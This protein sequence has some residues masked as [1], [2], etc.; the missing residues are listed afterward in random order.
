MVFI[1]EVIVS[2]ISAVVEL[3]FHLLQAVVYGIV[4]V[5][6][7]PPA[8]ES[9]FGLKNLAAAAAPLLVLVLLVL[10]GAGAMVLPDWWERRITK[11]C[12]QTQAAVDALAGDLAAA[13]DQDHVAGVPKVGPANVKDAWGNPLDVSFQRGAVSATITVKSAGKDEKLGTLD[14][15]RADHVRML[16]KGEIAGNAVR[17]LIE[18][19]KERDAEQD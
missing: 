19:V 3:V 5:A 1:V 8:G 6:R 15:I 9:R 16:N 10:A 7:K 4:R 2:G 13:F 18:Q 11:Q 12:D 17:K 14:D